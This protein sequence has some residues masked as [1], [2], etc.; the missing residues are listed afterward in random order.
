MSKLR[1]PLLYISH[2]SYKWDFICIQMA[3]H[4]P[5]NLVGGLPTLSDKYKFGE[6]SR[7][8]CGRNASSAYHLQVEYRTD[9]SERHLEW[10][11]HPHSCSHCQENPPKHHQR[12]YSHYFCR[13][14]SFFRREPY[15]LYT[16]LPGAWVLAGVKQQYSF[17]S[18]C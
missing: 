11:V 8:Q 9:S 7:L 6:Q 1:R 18:V 4:L 3:P 15:P 5:S 17:L 12:S 13:K 2:C 16:T 14:S 10:A